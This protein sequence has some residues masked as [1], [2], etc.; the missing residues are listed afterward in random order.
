[1]TREKFESFIQAHNIVLVGD[2]AWGLWRV[3]VAGKHIG[4]YASLNEAVQ[5]HGRVVG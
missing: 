5:A 3:D 2:V 4:S 1:M